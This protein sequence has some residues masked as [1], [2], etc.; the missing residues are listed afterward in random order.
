MSLNHPQTIPL[1]QSVE[2]LSSTKLVPSAK[3]VDDRCS[4][5]PWTN[6]LIVL[7]LSFLICKEG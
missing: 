7:N 1:P 2:K 6:H 5:G 4:M 3:K